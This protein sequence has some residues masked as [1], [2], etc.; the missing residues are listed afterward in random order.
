MKRWREEVEEGW[1]GEM[2]LLG[3]TGSGSTEVAL[4]YGHSFPNG[5]WEQVDVTLT[6]GGVY[7]RRLPSQLL[8]FQEGFHVLL[9]G[10]DAG[11]PIRV[12]AHQAALHDCRQH[13]HLQQLP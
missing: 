5:V 6:S 7:P 12:D 13:Q 9:V 11:L 2:R 8:T 10:L 3:C 4:P 1:K